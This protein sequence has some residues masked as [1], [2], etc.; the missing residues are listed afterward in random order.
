MSNQFQTIGAVA[1]ELG[2][3]DDKLRRLEKA[4]IVTPIRATNGVR[5]FSEQDKAR[6]VA[7]LKVKA[8]P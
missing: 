2:V 7:F 5:I 8:A 3:T 6:V 1:K 4:G